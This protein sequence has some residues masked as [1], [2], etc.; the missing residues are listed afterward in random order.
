MYI[1]P[2]T[3]E[4]SHDLQY[5]YGTILFLDNTVG[6]LYILPRKRQNH[7]RN[8]IFD[9]KRQVSVAN[10][11]IDLSC[12]SGVWNRQIL[13]TNHKQHH[14][15]LLALPWEEKTALVPSFEGQLVPLA[16][17]IVQL[18]RRPKFTDQRRNWIFK[19]YPIQTERQR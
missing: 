16:E 15:N 9:L 12:F 4:R 17:H 1:P 13:M 10:C 5:I 6:K 7:L 2:S 19:V 18:R 3:V 14:R 8:I 11:P